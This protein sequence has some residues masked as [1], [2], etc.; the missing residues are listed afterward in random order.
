MERAAFGISQVA[1]PYILLFLLLVSELSDIFDGF[2][3]RRYNQ[4]TDLGKILDPMAD[5]I[6]RTSVF[7]TFTLPP[8]SVPMLLVFVFLY[9]DSVIGTLRTVCALRGFALAAR[10]SGKVKAVVQA[11]AAFAILILMIPHS[12]GYIS[13]HVLR[14]TSAWIVAGAGIYAVLSG[15]DY[16]YANRDYIRQVLTVPK[17]S[18]SVEK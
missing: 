4:V 8:I 16:L 13:G 10:V 17:R 1:L 7:L 11:V 14:V 12:L 9:R 6:Y 2:L 5:S 15:I 18:R 3:A